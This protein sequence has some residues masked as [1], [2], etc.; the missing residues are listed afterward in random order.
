[1]SLS[2][3]AGENDFEIASGTR[4]DAQA[5]GQHYEIRQVLVIG[6]NQR[7]LNDRKKD[8]KIST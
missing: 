6:G 1:L 8:I 2:P 5:A 7:K 4:D 3:S